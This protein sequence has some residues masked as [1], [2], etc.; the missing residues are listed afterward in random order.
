[1]R[2]VDRLRETGRRLV[3]SASSRRDG[4]TT[5][6]MRAIASRVEPS[7][8]ARARV[9]AD[10]PGIARAHAATPSAQARARA[11]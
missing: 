3:A 7:R 8:H 10:I 5:N 2:A 1:M 4:P 9:A 6:A 11:G